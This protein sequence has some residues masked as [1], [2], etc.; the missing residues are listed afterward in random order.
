MFPAGARS[1][2]PAQRPDQLSDPPK[3][4]PSWLPGALPFEI[5]WLGCGNDH[6]GLSAFE[7][8][9]AWSYIFTVACLH[10]VTIN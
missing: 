2:S 8:K 3:L 9:N 7:V 10:G 6:L 4:L 5:K 1:A